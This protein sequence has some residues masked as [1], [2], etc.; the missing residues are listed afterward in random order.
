MSM[1][2][3]QKQIA[4][5]EFEGW[6]NCQLIQDDPMGRPP[7]V[8]DQFKHLPPYLNSR[9]AICGA[10]E[11]LDDWDDNGKDKAEYSER[12]AYVVGAN[13]GSNNVE[14]RRRI[15]EATASQ[16]ADALLLTLRYQI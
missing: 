3:E 14:D 7:N 13:W 11:K 15:F 2:P 10:V 5:A 12:L 8:S 6:T 4:I 1:T 16:M 9:D